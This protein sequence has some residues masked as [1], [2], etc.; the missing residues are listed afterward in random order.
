VYR[1]GHLT[2]TCIQT[3][4]SDFDESKSVR[5]LSELDGASGLSTAKALD[6]MAAILHDLFAA[7]A[8]EPTVFLPLDNAFELFGVDF[9]IDADQRVHLLEV[10]AGPDFAQTGQRLQV[11]THMRSRPDRPCRVHSVRVCFVLTLFRF[12]AVMCVW[13]S[14]WW[15]ASSTRLSHWWW[16]HSLRRS[17]Q[18]LPNRPM[19]MPTPMLAPVLRLTKKL[20]LLPLLPLPRPPLRMGRLLLRPPPP[21]LPLPLSGAVRRALANSVFAMI[22]AHSHS[23]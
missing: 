21:R 2:N 19:P 7:V 13:C 8:A 17:A 1:A 6:A 23:E 3:D 10:N 20:P 12:C 11:C 22:S 16:T 15:T 14:N 4:R 5:S 18:K 9:L